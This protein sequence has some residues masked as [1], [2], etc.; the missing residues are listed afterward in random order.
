[1]TSEAVT[2]SS[3]NSFIS[4]LRLILIRPRQGFATI[5]D[6]GGRAWIVMALLGLGLVTLP[7]IVSGPIRANQIREMFASQDFAETLPPG[8][9]VPED[10]DPASAAA[11]PVITTVFPVVGA[12]VLLL[13]GWVVWSGA[14]HLTSSLAGGRNSFLQMVRTVIWAWVP[15]GVRSLVQTIYIGVTGTLIENPGLSGFV[16]TGPTPESPF[17]VTPPSTGALALRAFLEQID[18]YLFWNLAL[19]VIG[20]TVVAQLPRRKSVGI[21]LGIWALFMLVRIIFAAASSGLAGAISP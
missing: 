10:F 6:R 17:A 5:A 11:S 1:M 20:V 15:Y 14:L 4:L 12:V 16:D 19:L 2:P 7:A 3:S 8:A 21:V 18:L 13:V 9:D